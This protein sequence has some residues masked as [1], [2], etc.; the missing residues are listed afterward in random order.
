MSLLYLFQVMSYHDVI[1][2]F[3]TENLKSKLFVFNFQSNDI[4][5]FLFRDIFKVNIDKTTPTSMNFHTKIS[6][7]PE[8]F[9]NVWVAWLYSSGQ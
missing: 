8:S 4:K 1:I 2:S 7:L 5:A 6:L 9:P 3:K